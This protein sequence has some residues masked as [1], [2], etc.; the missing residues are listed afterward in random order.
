MKNE[1]SPESFL[2]G[3]WLLA[4][5]KIIAFL[6]PRRPLNKTLRIFL[7]L[8][9]LLFLISPYV[10]FIAY[11]ASGTAYPALGIRALGLLVLWFVY[12]VAISSSRQGLNYYFAKDAQSLKH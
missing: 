3:L 2:G 9:N 1:S 7:V 11:L 8:F 4:L 12:G 5:A 6:L 10:L